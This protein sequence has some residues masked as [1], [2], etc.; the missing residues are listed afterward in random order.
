MMT[1]F[2]WAS[3]S[4]MENRN[5]IGN[6]KGLSTDLIGQSFEQGFQG[7][8]TIYTINKETE[9]KKIHIPENKKASYIHLKY[10]ETIY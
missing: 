2:H 8:F 1:S 4:H 7:K 5:L 6:N 10:G 9:K 3:C